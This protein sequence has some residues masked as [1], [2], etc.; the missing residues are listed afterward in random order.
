MWYTNDKVI[1]EDLSRGYK[2]IEEPGEKLYP[3]TQKGTG[4]PAGI[5]AG[6]PVDECEAG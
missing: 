5:M 4:L 3:P 2:C 6:L 1:I